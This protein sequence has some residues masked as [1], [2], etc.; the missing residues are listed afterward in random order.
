[1]K[2]LTFPKESWK[3]TEVGLSVFKHLSVDIT[4]LN[5]G[6]RTENTDMYK[7][8]LSKGISWSL[9]EGDVAMPRGRN[10]MNCYSFQDCKWKKS[11]SGFVEVPYIISDYFCKFRYTKLYFC[12]DIF[13]LKWHG[14][15]PKTGVYMSFCHSVG[16]D[17]GWRSRHKVLQSLYYSRIFNKFTFTTTDASEKATIERA[18]QVFHEKTCVR[19]V[20]H[21]NQVHYL[22]LESKT[23]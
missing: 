4:T 5:K 6:E 13:S 21:T 22:S 10:A 3:Q 16:C 20:P 8:F 18:M 14:L 17:S 12:G 2:L 9:L 1:M 11:P 19:F 15:Y 23:G 7:N